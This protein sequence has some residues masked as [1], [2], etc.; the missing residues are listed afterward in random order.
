MNQQYL[1]KKEKKLIS[2]TDR[3]VITNIDSFM[4]FI[5]LETSL[6]YNHMDGVIVSVH[7]SS[8]G[9]RGFNLR[10]DQIKDCI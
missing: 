4:S 9:D 1:E 5:C 3:L 6:R 7:D 8:S 10:L 2:K